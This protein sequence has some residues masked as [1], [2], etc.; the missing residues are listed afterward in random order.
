MNTPLRLGIIGGGVNSAIGRV[1]HIAAQM[2]GYFKVVAG[3][4]SRD[5]QVNRLSAHTYQTAVCETIADLLDRDLDAVAILTPTP[6]HEFIVQ[7]V[8]DAGIPVICEKALATTPLE[9]VGLDQHGFL[10]V[11]YN[12]TGYPMLREL[13]AIIGRG[14]LGRITQVIAEMPQEGYAI[15]GSTPQPWRLRDGAIP[16]IYLDLGVHLHQIILF[17]TGLHPLSAF[18]TEAR[19]GR[20]AVVDTVMAQVAYDEGAMGLFYFG[21]AA[22]G[23]RNGLRI[24]IFG[25]EASAEWKQEDPEHLFICWSEGRREIR[26]RASPDNLIA[27]FNNTSRFKPGHPSGYIE[28][29][30][31]TYADIAGALHASLHPDPQPEY[32]KPIFNP[33]VG[34]AAIA[35]EGLSLMKAMTVSAKIKRHSLVGFWS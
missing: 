18:A 35:T 21:K 5:P 12:Y 2:D 17:L 8:Q 6:T 25:S 29:F 11:T 24:R 7:L 16:T 30:A 27:D 14:D 33:Y 20:F 19:Y 23:Q 26:D 3:C 10:A 15:K 31:N 22:L 34:T 13:R 4:Y 28:A 1:H 32:L 9:A